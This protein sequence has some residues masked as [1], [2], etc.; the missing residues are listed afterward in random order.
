MARIIYADNAATT[1]LSRRA[2]DAMMPFLTDDYGNP[3]TIYSLGRTAKKAIESAR[4]KVAAAI[5]AKPEEIYFTA[6]GTE[7][8]NWAIKSVAA[9]KKDKGKHIIT[10]AI[11]HH[12]VLDTL[13]SLQ[14]QGYEATYLGVDQYGNISLEQLRSAIRPDTILITV[15]AANNEI[16]TV[17]PI[18]EIGAIAHEAGVLFHT[19]AVQAAGHIPIDVSQMNIDLLSMS[20]HKFKGPKGTGVL[21]VKKGLRLPSNMHGGAQERGL[22]SGTENV[23]GIVGLA[24]ALEEAV[25]NMDANMK[26]VSAMRDTLI[27]G[28]LKIPYTRLT[29]DPVNRLPGTAS[30]VFECVE[31]ESMILL[32]DQNGICAASGSACTSGSLDPSHVLLAI[33]LPHEIAHGS[34]RLTINEDNTQEDIDTILEKMPLIIQR[35]RDMSP[36]WEEKAAEVNK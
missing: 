31:G 12:A 35:L 11:E 7:S 23:P 36:L 33:G 5:G 22:R 28:L 1:R 9:L 8:D 15:M 32:L 13:K 3:S 4:F 19:D 26:K 18:R 30:F 14:K 20:G 17:L 10:T 25:G 21:Y 6:G 27:E 16:G 29:G 34:L 24:A 2:L